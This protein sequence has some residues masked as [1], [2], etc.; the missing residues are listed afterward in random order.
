MVEESKKEEEKLEKLS[1]HTEK[2]KVKHLIPYEGNPRQMTEK[3]AK[4]LEKSIKKFNLVDIPAVDTDNKIISGHQRLRILGKL[5]RHND[6]IDVRKPNR[7]L[8]NAEFEEYNIVS[9]KVEGSFDFDLLA[10]FGGDFFD[11]GFSKSEIDDILGNNEDSENLGYTID[12]PYCNEK[13]KTSNKVKRVD[14][15]IDN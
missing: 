14:K 5:G 6:R 12:C 2:L 11:V 7:K 8:T 15:F 13:I 1:W 10:N 3:Q 4:D 9:N